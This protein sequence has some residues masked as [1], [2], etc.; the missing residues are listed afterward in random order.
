MNFL[1]FVFNI[2]NHPHQC[3]PNTTPNFNPINI[4]KDFHLPKIKYVNIHI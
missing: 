2:Y 1:L 4:I 3:P